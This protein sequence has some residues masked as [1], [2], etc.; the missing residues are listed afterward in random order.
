MTPKN[1][2]IAE[3]VAAV[4]TELGRT[5]SQV[6]LAWLLRRKANTVIP[7]IGARNLGQIQDNLSSLTLLLSEDT[8]SRL[9]RVSAVSLGFPHDFLSSPMI[10]QMVHGTEVVEI[11]R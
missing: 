11:P 10:R 9:D 2:A 4:A 3:E 6:A 8:M 1:L 7:I 5:P